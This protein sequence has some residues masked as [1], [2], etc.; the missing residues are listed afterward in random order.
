[1]GLCLKQRGME[2]PMIFVQPSK[3]QLHS[4]RNLFMERSGF[5]GVLLL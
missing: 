2:M 4:S 5:G 3:L 1:M